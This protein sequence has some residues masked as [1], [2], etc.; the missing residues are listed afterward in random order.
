MDSL[1]MTLPHPRPQCL[2][3]RFAVFVVTRDR[4]DDF[5]DGSGVAT[6]PQ[7]GQTWITGILRLVKAASLLQGPFDDKKDALVTKHLQGG[8]L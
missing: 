5:A 6:L 1:V 8:V 3:E 7:G 2:G 4:R